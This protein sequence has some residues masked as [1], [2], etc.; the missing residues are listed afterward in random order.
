MEE[1]KNKKKRTYQK[2]E[3][4]SIELAFQKP[5]TTSFNNGGFLYE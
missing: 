2:M 4:T 5:L 1:E 3:V